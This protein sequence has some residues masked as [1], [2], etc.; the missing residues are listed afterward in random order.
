MCKSRKPVSR[1]IW[2]SS[3]LRWRPFAIF[4]F[5]AMLGT[6]ITDP[7]L[8][9][10]SH[11]SHSYAG[12]CGSTNHNEGLKSYREE[13]SHA[14]HNYLLMCSNPSPIFNVLP[15]AHYSIKRLPTTHSSLENINH[16]FWAAAQVSLLFGIAS[17]SLPVFLISLG[18]GWIYLPLLHRHL[19]INLG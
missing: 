6:L 12:C 1:W 9:G 8:L 17:T 7:S 14:L 10:I 5:V 15:K 19:C 11:K 2:P 3:L 4:S 16:T 18:L 13:S